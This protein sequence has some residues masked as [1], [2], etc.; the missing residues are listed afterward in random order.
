MVF[1]HLDPP[2]QVD[3]PEA[4]LQALRERAVIA[5][6]ITFTI[7]D[8]RQPD[9]PL[10]WVNPS[11]TRITG[12]DAEEAVGRN[13]RFLQGPATDPAAVA[14]IRAACGSGGTVT[15][16]LLNYRK[17]GTAFW[18]QLS[19]SP[20][21]DGEGE[22]VSFVGVQTDVTERV[23]V[24]R[25][26]EAAFAAEQAARQEAELARAIAEQARADAERAQAEAE[27]AQSRLALM[28]EA[29]SALI[30]TLDM[31]ELLDRLAGAVRARAG[32]LGRSS[33][34]STSYGAGPRDRRP[35]P[36]RAGGRPRRVRRRCTSL[37][38]PA[39]LTRAGGAWPPPGRCCWPSSS[40]DDARGRS[41]PYP[42]ALE[43]VPAA[44]RRRGADRADGGPP[45]HPR[46][47]RPGPGAERPRRSPRTTST[48][49]QDLAA[50]AALAMDNVRLY[51][52]EHTVADTLQRS[53]LPE[54]PEIPGIESRPPTT[55]APRTAA[56][57]G[58]DFYDLLHLPDGSVGIAVGDV[59]GHDV[60][61][62]AAMGHLRGLLRACIWDAE[63]ADP[64]HGPRP[65]GPAGAGAAGRRRWR[66]WSTPAPCGR[67]RPAAPW[68]LHV[69]NAGHPPMLLRAPDGRGPLARRRSPACWSASTPPPTARRVVLDVPG[70]VDA[71][72]LHRRADRAPGRGHGPRHPRAVRAR[73]RG[74]G[75]RRPARALRRRRQ[76][77]A[78]TTGTTSR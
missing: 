59:V 17:D 27:R 18:N 35:A 20:V 7:T 72:R 77:R 70:R 31:T 4:Y 14:E 37:H 36:R 39:R 49:P 57:V 29:T 78:S 58:G 24:E 9:N 2:E 5:T 32:R 53:L 3:D 64:R 46:R 23:R 25:E 43:A 55:S 68:R 63:D 15:T 8:P 74:A 69:A 61:A 75:R 30:A 52:Q 50:R 76:R 54:L 12:Y 19:I 44:G 21:F 73:R 11:F 22:L 33:P 13:C 60:A 51:Q 56:D 26:R 67:P 62:A 47:D 38:L 41:S 42:G 40:T 34:W 66:R 1:L 6:D 48:W 10:V 71:D 16:T 45:A 65:R 28:A